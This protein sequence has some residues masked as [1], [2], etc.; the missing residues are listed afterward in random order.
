MYKDLFLAQPLLGKRVKNLTQKV[1]I[2]KIKIL[3]VDC[4]SPLFIKVN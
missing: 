1:N 4:F 2:N 3:I